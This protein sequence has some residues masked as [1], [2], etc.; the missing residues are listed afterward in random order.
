MVPES[1]ESVWE[2]HTKGMQRLAYC[3]T[4]KT[5]FSSF[6]S[7]MPMLVE[8]GDHYIVKLYLHMYLLQNSFMRK[9]IQAYKLIIL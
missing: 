6:H 5:F 3:S 4:N 8:P 9:T 2:R 7:H 1:G